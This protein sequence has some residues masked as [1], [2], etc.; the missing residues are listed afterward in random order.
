MLLSRR[1][2]GYDGQHYKSWPQFEWWAPVFQCRQFYLGPVLF[3][4]S[5]TSSASRR[6][7]S[8]LN[9]IPLLASYVAGL[10][11]L[12]IFHEPLDR[13]NSHSRP[14]T[15]GGVRVA[16]ERLADYRIVYIFRNPCCLCA[17]ESAIYIPVH[18]PHSGKYVAGCATRSCGYFGEFMF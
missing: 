12:N 17:C 4:A 7:L 15:Q 5:T 3:S 18:G 9:M 1:R 8:F 16:P 2:L 13:S 14:A 10:G 11:S 6:Q